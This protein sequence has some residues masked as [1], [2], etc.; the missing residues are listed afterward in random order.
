MSEWMWVLLFMI[1]ISG[2]QACLV[3]YGVGTESPTW[4]RDSV[5]WPLTVVMLLLA[6]VVEIVRET[7]SRA[8]R[9]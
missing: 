8:R 1:Y 3:L 2:V 4:I 9:P 6:W 7:L 5:L